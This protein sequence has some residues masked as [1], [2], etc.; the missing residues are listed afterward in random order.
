MNCLGINLTKYVRDLSAEH[1]IALLRE[2]KGDRSATYQLVLFHY[3]KIFYEK[4]K[5]FTSF[6]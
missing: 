4:T 1:Y 3:P 2:I 6:F 5:V